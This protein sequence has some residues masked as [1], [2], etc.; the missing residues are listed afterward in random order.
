MEATY[1]ENLYSSFHQR[2]REWATKSN[3]KHVPHRRCCPD[4]AVELFR[5]LIHLSLLSE[6]DSLD[7]LRL[8]T[9]WLGRNECQ[10]SEPRAGISFFPLGFV[11]FAVCMAFT[12]GCVH[13]SQFQLCLAFHISTSMEHRWS[14]AYESQ[15]LA[16]FCLLHQPQNQGSTKR[17]VLVSSQDHSCSPVLLGV[18]GHVFLAPLL[19]LRSGSLRRKYRS[20]K[21]QPPRMGEVR[22]AA[23]IWGT[24]S[25][26]QAIT[27]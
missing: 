26:Q 16:N 2:I 13:L 23:N 1:R 10:R 5:A 22:A 19:V 3:G 15:T 11:M 18:I 20:R 12:P 9:K 25:I 24:G 7:T 4:H 6:R 17:M 14:V 8:I 27:R 21:A